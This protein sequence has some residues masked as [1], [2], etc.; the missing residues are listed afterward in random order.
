[1]IEGTPVELCELA[2]EFETGLVDGVAA[3]EGDVGDLDW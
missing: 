3:K 2:V 1:M